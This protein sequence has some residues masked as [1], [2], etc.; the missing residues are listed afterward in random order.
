MSTFTSELDKISFGSSDLDIYD[1]ETI[2]DW[3]EHPDFL[4]SEDSVHS[5][6]VAFID[7]STYS[8]PIYTPRT[9]Y[10]LT[11]EEEYYMDIIRE[12]LAVTPS[13]RAEFRAR[14]DYFIDHY[15]D[16]VPQIAVPEMETQ[17]PTVVSSVPLIHQDDITVDVLSDTDDEISAL[18]EAVPDGPMLTFVSPTTPVSILERIPTPPVYI[19][20]RIPTPFVYT[21]STPPR[22]R[23]PSPY[24][25]PEVIDLTEE[26]P[27]FPLTLPANQLA[28][29]DDEGNLREEYQ[30]LTGT[31]KR[32]IVDTSEWD[33]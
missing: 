22:W 1:S 28:A 18:T 21:P 26:H 10:S 12:F 19:P 3:V 23:P 8:A 27:I 2:N 29:F 30:P 13:G 20:E 32:K 17:V 31:R 14:F 6:D 25:R 15:G 24:P 4:S 7:N 9:T 5:S 33:I 16:E 11:P